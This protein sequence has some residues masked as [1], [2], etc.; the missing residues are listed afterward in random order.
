MVWASPL[1]ARG[2]MGASGPSFRAGL[3]AAP[4][5]VAEVAARGGVF[6]RAEAQ[7]GPDAGG[8]EGEDGV[9]EGGE[10]AD[11]FGGGVQDLRMPS[12]SRNVG[13]PGLFPIVGCLRRYRRLLPGVKRGEKGVG[14]P[15][16][17]RQDALG[18]SRNR[19]SRLKLRLQPTLRRADASSLSH[20]QVQAMAQA[21]CDGAVR[22]LIPG[23]CTRSHRRTD[24]RVAC[25]SAR[26]R[27]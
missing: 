27:G 11:G 4:L 13:V 9:E 20:F 12:V 16:L 15:L 10:D 7:L 23:C 8:G 22:V 21:G 26:G 2:K 5:E 3:E 14:P 25:R 19:P 24:H 18:L 1:S 6:D 17:S